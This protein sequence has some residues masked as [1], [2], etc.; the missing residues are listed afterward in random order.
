MAIHC[1]RA[2][3]PTEN[4]LKPKPFDA[5]ADEQPK[6]VERGEIDPSAINEE[7]FDL[8]PGYLVFRALVSDRPPTDD[9]VRI[10]V[11]DVLLPSLTAGREP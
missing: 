3:L 4:L 1:R 2:N 9:T 5:P 6:A 7:I 10:L 8:L 11:D